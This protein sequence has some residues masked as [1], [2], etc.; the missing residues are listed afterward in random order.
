MELSWFN[1]VYK[2]WRLLIVVLAL[3]SGIGAV[4]IYFFCESPKFLFNSGRSD[5]ALEV[6][7]HIYK[8]NHRGSKEEY[9]VSLKFTIQD[10]VDIHID[11]EEID[12][13]Q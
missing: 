2:P 13:K 11:I 6:L 3:P 10:L 5:E 4:A 1:I 7:R 8:V 9:A 12:L